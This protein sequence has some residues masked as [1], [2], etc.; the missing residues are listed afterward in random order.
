MK[1]RLKIMVL[2]IVFI[3][4]FSFVSACS[5]GTP[6]TKKAEPVEEPSKEEIA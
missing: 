2:F 4:I 1:M 6:E 5:Y 3:L